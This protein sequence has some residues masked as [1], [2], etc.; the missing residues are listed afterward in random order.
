MRGDGKSYLGETAESYGEVL[1]KRGAITESDLLA[2][3]K[4]AEEALI[5]EEMRSEIKNKKYN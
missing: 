1:L 3:E 4:N 5:N 2:A